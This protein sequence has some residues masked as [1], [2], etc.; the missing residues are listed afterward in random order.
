MKNY[1][2]YIET[3]L[4]SLEDLFTEIDELFLELRTHTMHMRFDGEIDNQE[5]Y[6]HVKENFDKLSDR[7]C[8]M[9]HT[10]GPAASITQEMIEKNEMTEESS[11]EL[12]CILDIVVLNM[13]V[14]MKKH[15][16]YTEMYEE[17]KFFEEEAENFFG[18][19]N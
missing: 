2:N 12:N 1:R 17:F 7:I 6:T 15:K 19:Q 8:K 13:N 10:I 16:M 11:D 5:Y 4:H 14:Y 3:T 18:E 9:C